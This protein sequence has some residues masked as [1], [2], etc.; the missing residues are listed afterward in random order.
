M[1]GRGPKGFQEYMKLQGVTRSQVKFMH[2]LLGKLTAR[3]YQWYAKCDDDD[4]RYYRW[5]LVN[6]RRS[7]ECFKKTI[8]AE[9]DFAE[10]AGRLYMHSMVSGPGIA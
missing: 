8:P 6:D 10:N 3:A 7:F 4:G 9:V 2:V 1:V 5:V